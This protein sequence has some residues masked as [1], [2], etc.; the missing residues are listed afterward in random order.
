M[1]KEDNKFFGNLPVTGRKG[2]DEDREREV[3]R[4][5]MIIS[6]RAVESIQTKLFYGGIF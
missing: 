3:N 5:T 6:S 2:L 4:R 1:I